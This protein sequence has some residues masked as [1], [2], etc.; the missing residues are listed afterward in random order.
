MAMYPETTAFYPAVVEAP[1]GRG[2]RGRGRAGPEERMAVSSK[3]TS[4]TRRRA[5]MCPASFPCASSWRTWP[6]RER[7]RGGEEEE[8]RVCVIL[9]CVVS[10]TLLSEFLSRAP[11]ALGA[12]SLLPAS[13]AVFQ[14]HRHTA[15]A[16][17]LSY[18]PRACHAPHHHAPRYLVWVESKTK[19]EDIF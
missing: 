14:R 5:S 9:F 17:A 4:P 2:L 19:I 8:E 12:L 16:R 15:L 11:S 13:A 18:G 10:Q 3:T 1:A 6:S 7:E